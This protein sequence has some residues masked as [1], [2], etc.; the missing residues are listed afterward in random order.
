MKSEQLF[1]FG[2]YDESLKV[3]LSTEKYFCHK[4]YRYHLNLGKLIGAVKKDYISAIKELDIAISLLESKDFEDRNTSEYLL[5]WAKY[6]KA[7][8]LSHLNR[9]EDAEKMRKESE[10]HSFQVSK[11]S[12]DF[13]KTFMMPWHPDFHV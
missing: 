2:N 8:Y 7:E 1:A 4:L 9:T 13:R 12:K 5:C 3:L 6:L 10:K 11:V